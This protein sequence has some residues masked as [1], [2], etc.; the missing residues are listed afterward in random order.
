MKFK[1]VLVLHYSIYHQK[2]PKIKKVLFSKK[3]LVS[4]WAENSKSLHFKR[5]DS[6]KVDRQHADSVKVNSF[7]CTSA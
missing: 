3:V 1:K 6:L 7:I 2:Y 5:F 4:K